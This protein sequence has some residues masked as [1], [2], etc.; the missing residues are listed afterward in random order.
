MTTNKKS[1]SMAEKTATVSIVAVENY[2]NPE[3]ILESLRSS[4]AVFGGMSSIVS[5]GQKVLLKVNL[6]APSAPD[7]AVT[8]HPEILRA[9]IKLVKEAGGIACVGDGPGVGDTVTNMKACG[10]HKVVEEEGAV[11]LPFDE[12]EVFE[13]LDN[14]VGKRVSLTKHLNDC[15]VVISLPKLKTHVQ[16]AYT[17]ALKNQYG[18]IPGSTKGQYHFRFQDRD[19]LADLMVDINRI[20]K[21]KL[22]ILDAIVAMEGEG[23][24]G[25]Q[26]RKIGALLVSDD[27]TAVDV[28]GC[29]LI[30]LDPDKNPLNLAARRVDYGTSRLENINVVGK[31]IDELK[32]AD[33]KLV[34]API[35]IMKILPLPKFFLQYL[36]RLITARPDINRDLCIGC[37]KCKEGCPVVPPA[38]DPKLPIGKEVNCRTCIRCY[39]C[40]EFCPVKAID[41]KKSKLDKLLNFRKIA[42]FGSKALGWIVVKL[43]I[44]E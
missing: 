31:S 11:V 9:A 3:L 17:G 34:K 1:L 8:T 39:C 21:P 10:L 15:P 5:P 41:L 36:R 19:Q 6:L 12:T 16:M 30:N 40:H 38:I 23:P 42:D 35:N 4:L 28:V 44:R 37:M 43:G 20:A 24:S 25:G 26:P 13:K 27:L 7:R 29:H 14:R 33:F 32:V 18:L 2:L 22:A